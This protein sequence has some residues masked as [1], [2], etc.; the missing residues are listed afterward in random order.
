MK[1]LAMLLLCLVSLVAGD[2]CSNQC[3]GS[4]DGDDW[5]SAWRAVDGAVQQCV[6]LARYVSCPDTGVIV[7]SY[8]AVARGVSLAVTMVRRSTGGAG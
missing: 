5:C 3:S 2:E 8:S 1:M 4:A 6:Q 7:V